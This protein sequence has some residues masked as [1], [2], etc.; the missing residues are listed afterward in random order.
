MKIDSNLFWTLIGV[1]G[2]GL[3]SLLIAYI[4]RRISKKILKYRIVT[5]R[6]YSIDDSFFSLN[7]NGSPVKEMNISHVKLFYRGSG[8]LRPTD[9]ITSQPL[10]LADLDIHGKIYAVK[11]VRSVNLIESYPHYK[12][13]QEVI[14]IGIESI[15]INRAE[16][17]FEYIDSKRPIEFLVF[18]NARLYIEGKMIDGSIKERFRLIKK[19]LSYW[20]LGFFILVVAIP[21]IIT[22]YSLTL[23]R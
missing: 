10:S 4:S 23:N 5:E 2:G 17:K 21:L 7:H 18:H 9:F 14:S 11:G 3:V 13:G 19:I 1:L 16:L 12:I 20:G 8:L 15:D 22:A 6:Y